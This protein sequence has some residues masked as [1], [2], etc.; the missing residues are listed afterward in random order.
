MRNHRR[1]V[2]LLATAAGLSFGLVGA[3]PSSAHLVA[4]EPMGAVTTIA[5]STSG[6]ADV[7]LYDDATLSPKLTHNP[8]VSITGAGRVVGFRL[9]R[10]D[11]TGDTLYAVRLPKFA[12]DLTY[13]SGSTTP[14]VP[15]CKQPTNPLEPANC[16]AYTP[17]AITLHEGYYH[18]AVLTDGKPVK[19]TLHLHGVQRRHGRIGLQA[20]VRTAEADLPARESIGSTTITY[21][22]NTTYAGATNTAMVVRAKLHQDADLIADSVCARQDSGAPPPYAFS[23]P[24][25]GGANRG[26]AWST[27]NSVRKTFGAFGG[28]SV[29][30]LTGQS[31]QPTGIGGSFFDSDGPA[32]LGGIGIWTWS[33]ELDLFGYHMITGPGSS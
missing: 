23:P 5:V 14:A 24:C 8:D 16:P 4:A 31:I 11:N 17:K 27:G 7:V 3:L 18:L 20:K 21:G 12:G 2:A 29:Y 26:I 22:A 33:P 1:T 10:T 6:T 25:P 13:V 19:I 15:E 32:Y 28:L 30:D 9:T